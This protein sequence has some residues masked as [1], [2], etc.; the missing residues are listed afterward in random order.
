MV[1]VEYNGKPCCLFK[2]IVLYKCIVKE[3]FSVSYIT[4]LDI[5]LR[6]EASAL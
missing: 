1:V 6:I 2:I 4:P 3:N 5:A